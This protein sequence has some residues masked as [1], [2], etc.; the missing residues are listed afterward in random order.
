MSFNQ[1]SEIKNGFF[2]SQTHLQDLL[3]MGN[4][5][6]VIK[7]GMFQNLYGL[8]S[9]TL[10]ENNIREVQANS[11][12]HIESLQSLS[13]AKNPFESLPD[14]V[15]CA[16]TNTLDTIEF[17]SF[18]FCGFAPHARHCYP[19]T[20]GLSSRDHMLKSVILRISVWIVGSI[21]LFGNLFVLTTRLF[22][23][24]TKRVHAFLIMNL[25]FADLLMGIYLYLIAIHGA[26]FRDNYILY[27]L[28]WRSSDICTI[29]GCLSI[30]SSMM[31][32]FTLSVI[33]L[34]RYVSIVHPF[35]YESKSLFRAA[36]LMGVLWLFGITLVLI[37]IIMKQT[38]GELFYGSNGVCLPLQIRHPWATGWVFTTTL[39]VGL[40]SVFF[41]FVV[42]AYIA[43]FV[44]IRRSDDVRSTKKSQ[45]SA[46]L[47]RFTLLV[48]TDMLCWLPICV[49]KVL[50]ISGYPVSGDVYSWLA[51][52]V[53]PVNA[54]LNP[55]LYTITSKLFRQQLRIILHKCR[56]ATG[57]R[58]GRRDDDSD[59]FK[60]SGT[61]LSLIPVR[62][63]ASLKSKSSIDKT[64]SNS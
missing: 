26:L 58:R 48:F 57:Y 47:V 34:D 45:D 24:E 16:M 50:A 59:S 61:R 11:L 35:S 62:S 36:I 44:M 6:T 31:S 28:V 10:R 49:I 38:F 41:L 39:F 19:S 46:I 22:V 33:T 32:V 9:M 14:H 42:Y 4:K 27:D 43:M 51:V 37:P 13:L 15:F 30:L 54:A 40:N 63:K 18:S 12:D 60:R 64:K 23:N 8:L 7:V 5:L 52:F 20:D 2:E 56:R 25:A 53:L 55:I 29:A 17:D 1:I 3:L 21:A